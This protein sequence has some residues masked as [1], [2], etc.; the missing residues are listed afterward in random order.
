MSDI[1]FELGPT[2]QATV[3]SNE[4]ITPAGSDEV[5][6]LVLHVGDP[7][8]RFLE[9]QTV[10]VVVPGPHAFGNRIHLRR[11]SVA[12][13]RQAAAE[14]G[15]DVEILVRRCFYV[16]DVSGERYPG[17]ASNFL[18]DA[19][20]GASITLSGP[21]RSP[22]R[23]PP[24]TSANLLMIG[25]GTGVAPFRGFIQHIYKQVGGW[26]G[27]VRLFYGARTGMELLYMN[28]QNA[29]LAN[30][31]DEATFKAFQGVAPR[32]HL[33]AEAGLVQSITEHTRE[34][35]ELVQDPSTYVFV[36]GL[37]RV[38]GALDKAMAK[39]AGSAEA[40][41]QL[42]ARLREEDRWSEL[43]YS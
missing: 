14:E 25:V 38:E 3:K 41:Q 35:W 17:V 42:K 5:R 15:V 4:R 21:Y 27:K 29:D 12:N 22:F 9:G 24:G 16:D 39:A 7:A 20:P 30:Y 26:Q 10:G 6:H 40:W 34:V 1:D 18:C 31:Y 11:Y 37:D 8:F 43:I 13:A 19:A 32:A 23:M 28:D 36:A 2:C 33:G